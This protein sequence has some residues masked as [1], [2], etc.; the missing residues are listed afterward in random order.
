M[1]LSDTKIRTLKP[2]DK[3]YKRADERGLFLLVTPAGGKLWRLKYRIDNK[4][5]LLTFGAYPDVSLADAREARDE[6]R[7]A[8]AAGD[9]PSELRKAVKSGK[10]D[11]SLNSF[12]V[13]AR[14]WWQTHMKN[15]ADWTSPDLVDVY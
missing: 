1:A 5:K 14:D 12:E 6:A 4:E 3:P 2:E 8:I 10:H 7:K 11:D 9:D 15:M 13:I